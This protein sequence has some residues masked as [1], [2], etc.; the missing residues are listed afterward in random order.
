M[1]EL[2][3]AIKLNFSSCSLPSLPGS[4]FCKL[5]KIKKKESSQSLPAAKIHS[6]F[7][8]CKQKETALRCNLRRHINVCMYMFQTNLNAP[9]AVNS[10]MLPKCHVGGGK[11]CFG[12][13]SN[14]C[15][16][17]SRF[18][19]QIASHWDSFVCISDYF[20]ISFSHLT[21]FLPSVDI[22][23][24]SFPYILNDLQPENELKAAMPSIIKS[25]M[26][27]VKTISAQLPPATQRYMATFSLLF[28]FHNFLQKPFSASISPDRNP[29]KL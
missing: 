27:N 21:L 14:K 16:S 24:L 23:V 22:F 15:C 5:L 7:H 17:K 26:D 25:T 29:K 18:R 3:H 28:W 9:Q 8:S 2:G 11:V 10:E 1:M 19:V 20:H 12:K 13:L 4:L 6:M